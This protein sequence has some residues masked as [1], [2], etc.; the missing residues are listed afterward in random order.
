MLGAAAFNAVADVE[1]DHA[2]APVGEIGETVLYVQIVEIASRF[3]GAHRPGDG[4]GGG[5]FS[6]PARYFFRDAP[7][8]ENQ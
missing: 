1:N 5:I 8:P 4:L 7:R 2:I 3:R 6:L